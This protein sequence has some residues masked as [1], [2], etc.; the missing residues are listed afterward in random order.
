MPPMLQRIRD[1]PDQG[2]YGV[3][4][5][6]AVVALYVIG[7]VIKNSKNVS[8]DFVLFSAGVPLITLMVVMLLFGALLGVVLT[9]VLA[10]RRAPK[11]PGTAL[12]T[13]PPVRAAA[14]R[15]AAAE[16]KRRSSARAKPQPR[17]EVE[18]RQH[19]AESLVRP[20]PALNVDLAR[21]T[22]AHA[23][24][25][26]HAIREAVDDSVH[27]ESRTA[28]PRLLHDGRAAG[29]RD[30]LDHVEAAEQLGAIVLRRRRPA[31]RS[32]RARRPGRAAA[33]CRSARGRWPSSA[34][35]TPPQP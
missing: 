33:S 9:L 14:G 24:I 12:G 11:R 3:I 30:L 18:T 19:P 5:V 28:V 10:R 4:G 20:P 35:C 1:L 16:P 34:A 7:F 2:L 23:E 26:Q 25:A 29:V 17:V 15:V 8:V 13:P 32:A 22:G 6:L 31:A 27:V 21:P